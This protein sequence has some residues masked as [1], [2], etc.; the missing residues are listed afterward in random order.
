MLLENIKRLTNQR[1][2]AVQRLTKERFLEY[3][4]LKP[5][6]CDYSNSSSLLAV[7]SKIGRFQIIFRR[8]P[9]VFRDIFAINFRRSTN[10]FITLFLEF[11]MPRRIFEDLKI[12]VLKF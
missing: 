2:L 3:L 8:E 1:N 7:M 10:I 12:S 9:K 5:H 11:R 4:R 6:F